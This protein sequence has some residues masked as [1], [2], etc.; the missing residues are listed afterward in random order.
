MNKRGG[1]SGNE[2]ETT[3]ETEDLITQLTQVRTGNQKEATL[4]CLTQ[5][6][7]KT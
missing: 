7:N 1:M 5:V 2:R 6:P 4:K 3:K